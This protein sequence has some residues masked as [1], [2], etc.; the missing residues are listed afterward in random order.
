[1]IDD[2]E[3][4]DAGFMYGL[5]KQWCQHKPI[6]IEDKF[7]LFSVIRPEYFVVT[8]NY[9]PQEIWPDLDIAPLARRF[10]MV[11]FTDIAPY[12]PIGHPAHTVT[13][14][15]FIPGV[16]DPIPVVLESSDSDIDIR[17][18]QD[19]VSEIEASSSELD[20]KVLEE[21]MTL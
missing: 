6:T 7:G 15:S 17:D 12:R 20:P 3:K 19:L 13:A 5:L 21:M 2:I 4:S 9:T 1:M 11:H 18:L 16:P 8:S 10:R 14:S